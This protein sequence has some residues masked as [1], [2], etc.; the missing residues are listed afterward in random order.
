M[1]SIVHVLRFFLPSQKQWA[2]TQ[3]ELQESTKTHHDTPSVISA[4]LS[5]ICPAILDH[6]R[7]R[8]VQRCPGNGQFMRHSILRFELAF[9]W[10]E[11]EDLPHPDRQW[12]SLVPI[13][14][15]Y[16]G[17]IHGQSYRQIED[18]LGRSHDV[19]FN[20]TLW[21]M[22]LNPLFPAWWFPENI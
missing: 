16:R 7:C 11:I 19:R 22:W 12:L 2:G 13:A 18:W 5:G 6:L 3:V 8:K 20:V 9:R 10:P 14:I 21:N 1:F 17:R 4:E 15:G